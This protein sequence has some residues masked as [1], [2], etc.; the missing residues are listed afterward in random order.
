MAGI[1]RRDA[2][3]RVAAQ[4]QGFGQVAGAPVERHGPALQAGQAL[5]VPAGPG[6]EEVAATVAPDFDAG[7]RVA[8]CP[9][10]VE[11]GGVG[12]DQA[13]FL[14]ADGLRLWLIQQVG[15][16]HACDV[17]AGAAQPAAAEDGIVFE[18]FGFGR[19]RQ[20]PHRRAE[21]AQPVRGGWEGGRRW[22]LGRFL[23]HVA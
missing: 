2:T 17:Q 11:A 13:V 22:R 5:E 7:G 23:W 1:G 18:G 9:A 14:E 4:A 20:H 15:Q 10:G 21:P 3:P 8:A 12:D 6:Q 16:P 19:Q